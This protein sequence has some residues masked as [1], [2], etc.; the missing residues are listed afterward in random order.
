MHPDYTIITPEGQVF[1]KE[2][3]LKSYRDKDRHWEYAES[4]DYIIRIY[5][6]TAIVIGIWRARG[7]N[8]GIPFDYNTRYTSMWVKEENELRI[9][10]DQSTPFE[11]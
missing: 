5:G 7:V 11:K 3:A 6:I 8:N 4:S 1:C 9:V 2:D 10:S